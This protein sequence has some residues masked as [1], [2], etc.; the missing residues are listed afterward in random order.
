MRLRIKSTSAGVQR[1]ELPGEAPT[2]AELTAA[3]A[4]AFDLPSSEDVLLS[5]NNKVRCGPA[6]QVGS[7]RRRRRQRRQGFAHLD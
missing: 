5:F 7:G 3:A 6:L 2:L 1:L 4:G